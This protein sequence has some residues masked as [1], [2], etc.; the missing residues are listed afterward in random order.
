MWR[1]TIA[2]LRIWVS[3]KIIF[4]AGVGYVAAYFLVAAASAYFPITPRAAAIFQIIFVLAVA[5]AAAYFFLDRPL[6]R[7]SEIMQ[8]AGNG[9]WLIRAPENDF[10]EMGRLSQNFNQMLEQFSKLSTT[11]VSAEHN[12]TLAHEELK[13]KRLI[14][15][16]N[17][18]L[19]NLVRDLSLLYEIGQGINKTVELSQLYELIPAVLQSNLKLE[20][21]SLMVWDEKIQTLQVKAAFGF[22]DAEAVLETNFRGGEGIAGEVLR[23]G[24]F[25]YVGDAS[26]E[27]RFAKKEILITGSV[28]SVPLNY[29][30]E[31]LGVIN[32]GR[33]RRFG[34][35]AY[36]TKMLTLVANQV[37]LAMA[38]AKLYT[39]TRELSVKDELTGVHNRRHFGHVLQLEWKRAIRFKRELSLLMA[40]VDFFK[41][42]NDTY[43]H[44]EG[45]KVLRSIG[46]LLAAN[47]REVDTV[48]RFGGEEFVVLL[49]DTDKHGALAVA[50]KLRHL[51][52]EK[53]PGITVSIGVANHPEDVQEMEDMIDHAD[54]ALYEAKDG[55]RNQV[56]TYRKEKPSEILKQS[57]EE[58]NQPATKPRI[59]H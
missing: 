13:Y 5:A 34:F 43:G 42:Y 57:Q 53:I 36:D 49:P 59:V 10:D 50:E 30:G 15:Q 20:N 29:K 6:L 8:E 24:K 54:I 35:N 51:V 23:T 46:A 9:D 37:A 56:V 27:P 3:V 17:K 11:K 41:R 7:L 52:Q 26:V 4:A 21:F 22:T 28:L 33:A 25:I 16:T 48:A 1:D 40:D 58:E 14:E 2:M 19:E 12:L 38:N 47:L 31:T 32:F 18:T 44:L 55:G 39:Q 45:D